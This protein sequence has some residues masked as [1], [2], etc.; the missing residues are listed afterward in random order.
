MRPGSE[1]SRA[2]VES[3]PAPQAL[4]GVLGLSPAQMMWIFQPIRVSG[5]NSGLGRHKLTFVP[6]VGSTA[7][8]VAM[9]V[10]DYS[11]SRSCG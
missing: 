9:A 10:G 4:P 6:P 7:G 3:I 2:I 1:I 8:N 11:V 5:G